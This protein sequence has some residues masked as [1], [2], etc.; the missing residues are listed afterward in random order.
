[1]KLTK[2][3]LG[4][5]I[6]GPILV[7]ILLLTCSPKTTVRMR[8]LVAGQVTMAVKSHPVFDQQQ[9][10]GLII[11]EATYTIYPKRYMSS[12]S[13]YYVNTFTV[14]RFLIFHLAVNDVP[15]A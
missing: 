3:Q 2:K 4:W 1:M 10:Q 15:S 5:R 13:S 12:D 14:Y 11:G 6:G 7:L 9:R 8:M